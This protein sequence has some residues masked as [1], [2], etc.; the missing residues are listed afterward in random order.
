MKLAALVCASAVLLSACAG[1]GTEPESGAASGTPGSNAA[2]NAPGSA[3]LP[4]AASSVAAASSSSAP[5]AASSAGEAAGAV[6]ITFKGHW[7]QGSVVLGHAPAGTQIVFEG[8]MLRLT[9]D[10]TFVI[11][12]DRDEKAD[13]SLDVVLPWSK[14]QT[15]HFSVE[16]RHYAVQAINGLPPSKVNAPASAMN[17]IR[18]DIAESRAARARDSDLDAFA[19]PFI[20]PA[21]GRISGVFGSQRILNGEP[22]QPHYGVDVA[23]PIGTPVRAPADG[24]VS[25]VDSHMYFTGG[26]LMLDHGHGLTSAFLHLSKILVHVGD[27]VK[28]GQV[29]ARSG[30]TGR[31]TGPHLDWRVNWFDNHVDAQL[32]VPPMGET[33]GDNASD[34]PSGD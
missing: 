8:H 23:V 33:S 20:W 2:A 10:G 30:M 6:P 29:I 19:G 16:P 28:Q 18:H 13:A 11:G 34:S 27:T 7:V 24:I 32:L 26:T 22:K 14:P 1:V 12:L 15:L 31:A 17:H 3:S 25:L 21:S 4:S 5:A 9:K